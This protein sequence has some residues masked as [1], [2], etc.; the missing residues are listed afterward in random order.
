MATFDT[1][2]VFIQEVT[3]PGVIAGVGTSTAAFVGPA[4]RGPILEPR[5]VSSFDEFLRLYAVR[6]P[7]T[8]TFQPFITSPHLFYMAHAV[9]GFFENGGRQAFIVRAGT[10]QATQWPVKNRKGGGDPDE[11]HQD[12][13]PVFKVEALAEGTAGDSLTVTVE[14]ANATGRFKVAT[15]STK[16]TKKEGTKV[17]VDD[18]SKFRNRDIVTVDNNSGETDRVTINDI[19]G[20]TLT[21]SQDKFAVNDTLRIAN[22]K[23]GPD[24]IRMES[25]TGL[26]RGAVVEIEGIEPGGTDTVTERALIANVDE[27]GFV[28]F[29]DLPARTKVFD[30]T[31]KPVPSLKAF[32]RVV[33]YSTKIDELGPG[34]A[35]V[36]VK[37][38]S[39]FRVDD[40]VTV[41]IS[42]KE[43][44]RV[45]IKKIVENRLTLSK[46][47]TGAG[48]D[49]DIRI[50][51][52]TSEQ[53]TIRMETIVGLFPG[54]VVKIEGIDVDSAATL[55]VYAVVLSVAKF[56]F[57]TFV[58]SPAPSGKVFNL[59]VK[60]SEPI[61]N[62]LE[63]TL[64]VTSGDGQGEA[65]ENLSLDRLH[66]RFVLSNV[67]SELVRLLPVDPPTESRLPNRLVR[68]GRLRP[69]RQ[70]QDDDP[71]ILIA[72]HYKDGLKALEDVDDVNLV[73]IPDASSHGD[74]ES[75]QDAM[76]AHCE[77]EKLQDRFA[78]LDSRPG[79]PPTGGSDSVEEQRKKLDSPRGF[80][81]LYYPWLE[82]LDP[83][84]TTV[85]ARRIF[86][87]P[88]GHLAGIYART[89]QERGVHKA[90]A[91]TD[92]RGVL[93]LERILSDGQ[94]GP[95][96][97]KGINV[98][99][100]FP[101]SAT[102]VV[103]GARTVVDPNITD[104]LYVSVRRLLLF[105]EESIAEGIRFAVFEPNNQA[106][107]KK[108]E[109][110]IRE[111]LTRVWRDGA[112]FGDTPD[113][114]F[115]V[116]IDE[117]LNPPSV[118]ALGQLFIEIGVAAVRPA[119]FIIVRIGL[120]DDGA[121]VQE[122]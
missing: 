110:T 122:G 19:A 29:A 50:A 6:D 60:G 57:V 79:I 118:R 47:P 27:R 98:L 30:L 102:V 14:E 85:P 1:P 31:K 53:K 78:I 95:L 84:S 100:I 70:G 41:D 88:S 11:P 16:I 97:V 105:I 40:T 109:R 94:Q 112:L 73:C 17:T 37:D 9:R 67:R 81:A 5:R 66:P 8:G 21:L 32:V 99:R 3:G 76:I 48:K 38:A 55:S 65:F 54:S 18:A 82:V 34:P 93:G 56:G 62:S 28:T 74:W 35:E 63:F 114:A 51:N 2:G 116:R 86:V 77:K 26:S 103:W 101:G 108:L 83:T 49:S 111:F 87:P 33:A 69:S 10:A 89:D 25:V 13:E 7:D 43:G 44:D 72:G 20:D 121:D 24:A 46:I 58:T 113:K 96:N 36:L 42:G 64:R 75:I 71:S 68:I 107:W 61:V 59:A 119:E 15:H 90:P 92:V 120:R 39:G 52:L 104:W 22:L 115:R 45:T 4:L 80:G 117:G 91:N 12:D 23:P 106:L